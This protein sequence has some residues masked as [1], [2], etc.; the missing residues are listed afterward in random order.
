[1]RRMIA[2]VIAMSLLLVAGL[3]FVIYGFIKYWPH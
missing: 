1:M 2:L 3:G